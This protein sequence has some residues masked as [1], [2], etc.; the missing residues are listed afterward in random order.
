MK[1]KF[2]G[3]AAA[4]GFPA[5][6]CACDNCKKARKWGEKNL[7]T[8]SQA[9]IDD[10]LLID[11]PADTYS[12]TII[13]NI[14]LHNVK[15]CLITHTHG[16]HFYPKDLSYMK[17]GFASPLPEYKLTVYGSEDIAPHIEKMIPSSN[18]HLD[19]V[20]LNPFEPIKID[21]YTVTALKAYHGTA[22]PYIYIIEKD[23]KRILYAHD[24]DYFL[25]ETWEYLETNNIKFDVVSLDCTEGAMDELDYH[26]H[27]CL[28]RNIK[29]RN[30]M[31]SNGL[32]DDRTIFILN[33]FSHNGKSATYDEFSP[34][35]EKENFLV[36]YDGMTVEI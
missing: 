22:N 15:H 11:Y 9:I 31:L 16:D 23:G 25:P 10:C 14:D 36:S 33:H 26:C 13:H 8:R 21:A 4:E 19:F 35:A 30:R 32:A 6:F 1:L 7:R 20:H 12:H 24:T 27:M 17:K 5:M 28:G 29:C 34:I 2:L 18:S 3:T